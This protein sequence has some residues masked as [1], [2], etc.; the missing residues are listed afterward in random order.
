MSQSPIS[1]QLAFMQLSDSFFPS[2]SY[3]LSHGLESLVQFGQLRDAK[4]LQIFLQLLLQN[5]VGPTDAVALIHAYRGSAMADL[6]AVRE[7]D[8]QLFA[9]N[10]VEK[11]R[12]TGRKSGRALLMVASTTWPDAQLETLNREAAEGI[13]N[14]LHPIIFAVVARAAGLEERDTVLAFFHS[15]VTGLLGAAIRLSVIGHLQA[16][17]VLLQLAPD[18]EA[19]Y[20]RAAALRLDQMWSCTPMI[21][22][23]QMRH[24]KLDHRL[25]AS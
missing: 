25:F 8:A 18:I 16:Q 5:K 24:Q 4:D 15:F 19:A 6:E 7:A 23:A 17:Q 3:T 11:T 20:L 10:L 22:I 2:G 21:D 12:E 1:Q 9:Q 14:C 13:I